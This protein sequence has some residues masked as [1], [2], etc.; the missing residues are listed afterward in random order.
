MAKLNLAEFGGGCRKAVLGVCSKRC[1]LETTCSTEDLCSDRA[2][3][4]MCEQR[5][6]HVLQSSFPNVFLFDVLSVALCV[7]LRSIIMIA[8]D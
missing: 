4:Q 2:G 6:M 1:L 3:G 5:G 7:S 8:F